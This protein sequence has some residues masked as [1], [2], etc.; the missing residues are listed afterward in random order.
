MSL[1][2]YWWVTFLYCQ[3]LRAILDF[4]NNKVDPEPCNAACTESR[5]TTEAWVVRDS[6]WVFWL[7]IHL[8]F[9]PKCVQILESPGV[10]LHEVS[11]F[12]SSK[13]S[14]FQNEEFFVIFTPISQT[15]DMKRQVRPP[16]VFCRA[17][18]CSTVMRVSKEIGV[19]YKRQKIAKSAVKI[20]RDV[21]V[22]NRW[23]NVASL[24]QNEPNNTRRTKFAVI[25]SR[26]AR[27]NEIF[28]YVSNVF[29]SAL[30]CDTKPFS[31]F[32][33]NVTA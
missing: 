22:E 15:S 18:C 30:R 8:P 20:P 5:I 13:Y 19:K 25:K 10:E 28:H 6:F 3:V 26:S 23:W 1:N 27:Y 4:D 21:V 33:P 14:K 32:F 9:P 12:N 7:I 31:W 11:C 29:N 24:L 2:G 17:A 16:R